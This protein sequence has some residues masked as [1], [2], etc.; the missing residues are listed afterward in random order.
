MVTATVRAQALNP[1][2]DTAGLPRA[3]CDAARSRRGGRRRRIGPR[4]PRL[5][6]ASGGGPASR[7]DLCHDMTKIGQNASKLKIIAKIVN[8]KVSLRNFDKTR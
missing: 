6:S 8:L 1:P 5:Q 4:G 3:L 7:S 2:R